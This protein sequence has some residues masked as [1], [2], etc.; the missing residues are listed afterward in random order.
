M[1]RYFFGLAL[2]LLTGVVQAQT[3][4]C[5][6]NEQ[7]D[8]LRMLRRE[9]VIVTRFG[10][11]EEAV[12]AARPGSGV[13]IVAYDY[14][15]ID[16]K[17]IITQSLLDAAGKKRLRLYIEFPAQYPG[18]DV[19]DSVVETQLERGVVTS[20]VFGRQ[21]PSMGLLGIHN[22]HVLPVEA[23]SPL[24][25]LAKVVG[26]DKAEYGLADTKT[27]PLLFQRGNALVSMTGLSD[28][29][30]GRYGPEA[31]VKVL[32][33]YIIRWVTGD[34]NFNVK[35]WKE[36]VR[37]MYGRTGVLPATA[38]MNS[39]K[40]GVQW[41]DKGHFFIDP[42]WKSDWEKY[43]NNGVKPLG[44]PVS[45]DKAVGD[46]EL[47]ILEGHTSTVLYDGSQLYRYWMRADV[48]GEV[49]MALAA[50]GRLLN[51][52]EYKKK[53]ENIL[54]YLFKTSN[55]RAGAK[56]DPASPAYGLIGWAT[57]N[58]ETFYGD[59]NSRAILGAIATSAYLHTSEWDKELAEAIM[60]NFRTTGK[61][62]FR[63]ERLEEGDIIRN[64]WPFYYNRDLVHPSP[65]FESWMWACY[66]WLYSKT[67]YEPLLA[68]TKEAIRITMDAYPEKWLWGSSL[69]TQRARM[70]LPLAWLVR[71]EDTEEHRRWLDKMVVDMLGYQDTCGAIREEI[72][73]GK[74]MFRE[75]KKNS[76]YGSDE[77]SL[78]F[79]NGEKISCMLYTNNFALFS[80]NEAARATGDKRYVDA[81]RRLSDFLTR[82][83]VQSVKHKDLDG[84]WFRAFDYGKWDYWAS[85]SDAGWGAW[86]TLTGWIQSWI[87]ATQVQIVQ[88]Q[89]FWEVTKGADMGRTAKGVIASMM[90]L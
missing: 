86:C 69:Q 84:A 60:G 63:G 14:P 79:R 23:D 71:I 35:R 5:Y 76:D 30:T 51:N 25:V 70:I 87:V 43:G 27:Y 16:P 80:L 6:G 20:D 13:F 1:I 77:G 73:K 55:M 18:L 47:G 2:T 44:P 83:Q 52:E 66:L 88:G 75:L 59:D 17:N 42:S 89:S 65:H 48:Q 50:A 32:W 39:I 68:R 40:K 56:N 74:G 61:Q 21:L 33:N 3:V 28:F 64:G 54:N 31:Q 62:G 37:P 67:G 85:N 36:D 72:G 53:S 81:T 11:P 7:N 29:E 78:I 12:K 41:F 4:Y 45:Q 82:V 19:P 9:G 38:R 8:L 46:G 24:I 10:S 49:S 22:A 57:T 26:V 34:K 15:R 58:A 90:K